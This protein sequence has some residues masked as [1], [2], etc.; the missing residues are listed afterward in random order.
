M[1][2]R[3][4]EFHRRFEGFRARG[5]LRYPS[6]PE[7]GTILRYA[8]RLCPAHPLAEPQFLL[9]S[10]RAKVHS[11]VDYHT[12]YTQD[13][14]APYRLG[15]I[16]LEEGPRLLG[17]LLSGDGAPIQV[18]GRVR[19][20]FDEAGRLVAWPAEAGDDRAEA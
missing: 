2:E 3:D 17:I 15:L 14:P 13:L 9:A 10:G 12:S 5:E 11:A 8:Q 20:G 1:S 16:E 18:G 6:C 7:C 4:T 19:V